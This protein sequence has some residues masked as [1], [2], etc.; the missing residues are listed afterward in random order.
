[1]AVL[2]IAITVVAVVSTA[3]ATYLFLK[4]NPAKKA[5]IDATEAK[6]VSAVDNVAKKL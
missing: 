1:M 4:H 3:V 6:V 2:F 5:V